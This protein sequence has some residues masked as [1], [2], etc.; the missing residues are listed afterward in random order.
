MFN[1]LKNASILEEPIYRGF[2]WGYLRNKHWE[3]K[4][5]LL[6]QTALF[7]VSHFYYFK[8]PLTIFIMLP[9]AG[10]LFGYITM[11]SRSLIPAMLSHALYNATS[12]MLILQV[13]PFPE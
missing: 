4:R 12:F 7:T 11:K 2:L 3:E 13:F 5:I 10:L 8:H 6:F 1:H 9:L